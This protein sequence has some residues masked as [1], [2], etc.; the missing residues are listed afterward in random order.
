[1]SSTDWQAKLNGFIDD[2]IECKTKEQREL[3]AEGLKSFFMTMSSEFHGEAD[4]TFIELIK[5]CFKE[6]LQNNTMTGEGPTIKVQMGMLRVIDIILKSDFGEMFCKEV[7]KDALNQLIK[8]KDKEV[9]KKTA[10]YI[11]KIIRYNLH[12]Y[13]EQELKYIS[14]SVGNNPKSGIGAISNSSNNSS[15]EELSVLAKVM[16]LR[17]IIVNAPS[18]CYTSKK[19]IVSIITEGFKERDYETRKQANIAL[20]EYLKNEKDKIRFEYLY[21]SALNE[22]KRENLT[23]S[24][25]ETN[26]GVVLMRIT[27]LKNFKE[28]SDKINYYEV[29]S[30]LLYLILNCK[31]Q[32]I[33]NSSILSLSDMCKIDPEKFSPKEAPIGFTKEGFICKSEKRNSRMMGRRTGGTSNSKE[34]KMFIGLN[35]NDMKFISNEIPSF[36][37]VMKALLI[38]FRNGIEKPSVL[39]VMGDFCEYIPNQIKRYFTIEGLNLIN[40]TEFESIK[41]LKNEKER[42]DMVYGIFYCLSKIIKY[43]KGEEEKN[44]GI[45]KGI[46]ETKES[47]NK[48]N[49]IYTIFYKVYSDIHECGFN[50]YLVELLK[51]L[52]ESFPQTKKQYQDILIKMIRSV[53]FPDHTRPVSVIPI[54]QF[55]PHELTIL[56]LQTLYSFEFEEEVSQNIIPLIKETILQFIDSEDIEI[57]KE[58][59]CLGKVLLPKNCKEQDIHRY[60]IG[61]VV[62]IL[63]THGLSD[64][65]SRIRYSI[66][67]SFDERFDYYLS[68]AMNIQKLFIGMNDESFKVREQVICVIC[69]LTSY[70]YMYIIPSFRKIVIQL[71]SQLRHGVEILS[72]EES[73]ILI[74]DVIKTSGSLILP[75]SESI[76]EVLMPK[77]TD[78]LLANSTSLKRNL[79]IAIT[80]LISLGNIEEKYIHQ[81]LDAIVSILHQKGTSNQKTELRLTALESITKLVRSTEVA[82]GLYQQYPEMVEILMEIMI[83]ERSP[84]IKTAMVSVIGVLGALD[85]LQY[86][87]HT[88]TEIVEVEVDE[89]AELQIPMLSNQPDEYYAWTI[90]STLTK[91]LKDNT[92]MS[93]HVSCINTIGN[94]LKMMNKNQHQLFYPLVSY[95]F[96]TYVNVFKTCPTSIRPDVIKGIGTILP[97]GDKTIRDTYL[98]KLIGL[99]K[100]YWDGNILGEACAFC[101]EAASSIK[102]EFKQYLPTIIPI[103]LSELTKLK[104]S[105]KEDDSKVKAPMILKCF[106]TFAERL[107]ID[108]SLYIII[109]VFLELLGEQV[110][111][112]LRQSI[113]QYIFRFFTCV[114]IGEYA[115][116]II[117]TTSRLIGN[118]ELSDSVVM[119]LSTLAT[120]LGAQYFVFHPVVRAAIGEHPCKSGIVLEESIEKIRKSISISSKG[121]NGGIN[122]GRGSG[123]QTRIISGSEGNE[124]INKTEEKKKENYRKIMAVWDSCTQRSKKEE[125]SDWVEKIS[126]VFLKSNPSRIL[127]RCE[128]IANNSNSTVARDLFNCTFYSVYI[129]QDQKQRNELI[130]KMKIA[131]TQPTIT[132]EAVSLILNLAEFLE[133]EGLIEPMIEFGDKAKAIGAYAKALH[134]KE[135]EF[136]GL[137][138][139]ESQV[140]RN[141]L[142]EEETTEE[143]AIFEELIGLNNQLQRQD[144]ASGLIQM[145]EKQNQMK[146][147]STWYAKLGMWHKA[148]NKLEEESKKEEVKMTCLYE[149]GDWEALDEVASTFWDEENKKWK[150]NEKEIKKMGSMVAAS[151]FYLDKWERLK[152]IIETPTFKKVEGFEGTIYN[153]I[154]SIHLIDEIDKKQGIGE[155]EKIEMREKEIEKV[156]RII[157]NNQKQLGNEFSV[158][159]TEGYERIYGALTKAEM[160]TELEEIIEMK[161]KKSSINKEIVMKGWNERLMKSHKD[162]KTWQ[163]ILKMREIIS[164]KHENIKSWISF[165]GIIDKMGEEGLAFKALNKIAGHKIEGKIE[166]LPKDNFEVGVKYL[167][168]MW[169]GT[170]DI[171]EKENMYQLLEEYKEV[172]NKNSENKE[173][174]SQIY[175][176]LGE[177][178]LNISQNKKEFNKENIEI[179]L[180]HYQETIKLNKDNYKYWHRWALINFEVVNYYENTK[181]KSKDEIN[182]IRRNIKEI[183]NNTKEEHNKEKKIQIEED[184]IEEIIKKTRKDEREMVTYI[185]TTVKAF[186]QS[187]ILSNNKQTLQDT[188]RLLTILFKFGKYY[189]VEHAISSGINELPIEIWLH[190]VPQI[191]ARIQSEVGSVRRVTKEL[192]TIIGKAHPQAIV[193]ALTVASKSPNKDRKD[194][195]ISIIEKIKKESGHLVQQAMLVSEE[196][197]GAAIIPYEMWKEAIEL[198]SKEFYINKNFKQM[199]E[200]L[201]PLMKKLEKPNTPRDESFRLIY[202]KELKEAFEYCLRYEKEYKEGE[203]I[204]YIDDLAI[205]W[206]IY[207]RIYNRLNNTINKISRLELSLIAPRLSE[208]H[209]LDIAV[210][211][212]YKA[213]SGIITI[214]SI[215]PIL[216]VIPSKQRPR[217]LTIIGSNGKEYQYVLKG[218]EDLRQDERVMQLFGLVNDLLASNSETSKI[219]LFIHC[220]DVIPL[221]PMSGLI[222]WVPHSITIHQ[223]VKEYRNG[224]N[225]QVDTEKILCNRIAP[226][227]DNL[228]TLQKL[229]VFE[230]VLKDTKERE[231][232]LANAMWL[233][234]WTSEIW[235][236]RRTNFTRSVALMSMVGYIL[237]L[238]DRHPQN[239][240]LQKFTGDVVH[241]DFGDCFEVAMNREK[242]PEKI[243]FRLTRMIVNA[244]EVSGIEGTFRMTC[245]NVMTVLRENK[246]SLMA[247]L[248]AF[249]YD[250]LI[251]TILGG[252]D[253]TEQ[254]PILSQDNQTTEKEIKVIEKQDEK[255]LFSDNDDMTGA[256]NTKAGNVTQRVLDKLTGKDFGNE[257]LDVHNQVDKLIQQAISHENLCQCYQGWYPYW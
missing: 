57:R 222:G 248:E 156:K 129:A 14:V 220:Y 126:L 205:A 232:D 243:P 32:T 117:F 70:N 204:Q 39:K 76:I 223:F 236:E 195:A 131:L 37:N 56:A 77:L 4:S 81:T 189:E 3:K 42:K 190:V 213:N 121:G 200:V 150:L 61:Q 147:N 241:I 51:T 246:D 198:A 182:I 52:F 6:R 178:K 110:S 207:S 171:K 173:V 73:T 167:K 151:S 93:I 89:S 140:R 133:H 183:E 19:D 75:Y 72:V 48:S 86:R 62:Q 91:L 187:L 191:I 63:L 1:M 25:E 211:G 26:H 20:D 104:Y 107:N 10:K 98:P 194:V 208:A 188:L 160:I 219:H 124:E 49:E 186:V 67:S 193:Y 94:T 143:Q 180:K 27:I 85:P 33:R 71:V 177:W 230:R 157:E 229:E 105:K 134:Y 206:E 113:M 18:T 154:I 87:Q 137:K 114:N 221:S 238:G 152:A 35:E 135:I 216:E 254:T 80:E 214:K 196:L 172:I 74:G 97:L 244:M 102:D 9:M 28:S 250:P 95:I 138:N 106:L 145:A 123:E 112:G 120:K 82:I 66:M 159:A 47:N 31:S 127:S 256:Y 245:E 128:D 92:M 7:C 55:N 69:R 83:N 38:C 209:D 118:E 111:V 239:L 101:H 252:K 108:D 29:L 141:T 201:K 132:H 234:S 144:A 217:K 23:E 22:F 155:S 184:K 64:L 210:P 24:N 237:G 233:K 162:I 125:W 169:K 249:V 34:L 59:A 247:V 212:T 30:D 50:P 17:E 257:E 136:K 240:M 253:R 79:L 130:Q 161:K 41:K 168:L 13:I 78:E 181:K 65:D 53:L 215:Y 235:L 68:Q 103:L 218:H 2:L 231:M 228:T 45:E 166:A 96:S 44:G 163:K 251:V 203:E 60:D 116:R 175:S 58:V 43:L 100:E 165:T 185:E 15:Y 142:G 36:Y 192:L 90:I 46:E 153:I 99:I 12:D 84:Q 170:K 199:M 139:K 174:K 11:G 21:A 255:E 224:K 179:I 176:Q 227:Y 225:V 54:I 8:T 164:T 40:K 202:G 226:R 109:P 158:L 122:G 149:M 119:G 88:N 146:L 242:F 5:Y 197:V 115:G 16:V 148:L